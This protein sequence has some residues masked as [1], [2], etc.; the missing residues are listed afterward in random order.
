MVGLI[1]CW[2]G[3]RDIARQCGTGG[4]RSGGNIIRQC[5]TGGVHSV[6]PAGSIAGVE[7]VAIL[8]GGAAAMV[9]AAMIVGLPPVGCR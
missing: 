7:G 5:G 4:V 9:S 2:S 8:R 3:V 6:G 1:I